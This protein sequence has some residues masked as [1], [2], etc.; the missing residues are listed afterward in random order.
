MVAVR[1]SGQQGFLA[2]DDVEFHQSDDQC[3]ISPQEAA[4]SEDDTTT[5]TDTTTATE[6]PY[7]WIV[8]E[9][10]ESEGFCHWSSSQDDDKYAFFR[11]TSNGLEEAGILGPPTDNLE[12]KDKFFAMTS[13]FLAEE[14]LPG[15]RARLVSPTFVGKEHPYECFSFWFYFGRG[16]DGETLHIRL[17]QNQTLNTLWTLTDAY[18]DHF[19]TDQWHRG[20]VYYKLPNADLNYHVRHVF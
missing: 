2:F 11:N 4:V 17:V 19:E 20:Q 1:G 15:K 9:F 7:S 6:P 8:C 14:V 18:V 13:N 5:T 16:G 12:A 10:E 3:N